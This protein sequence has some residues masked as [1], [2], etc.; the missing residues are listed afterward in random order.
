MKKM[1]SWGKQVVYVLDDKGLTQETAV[2]KATVD[3][4]AIIRAEELPDWFLL[5]IGSQLFFYAIP[6]RAFT[7]EQQL[8]L[9]NLLKNK[10]LLKI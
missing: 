5:H 2:S 3:W 6:K 1:P 10:G 8:V 7:D 9:K 4:Q